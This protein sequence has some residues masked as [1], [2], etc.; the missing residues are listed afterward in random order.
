MQVCFAATSVAAEAAV[1]YAV[2]HFTLSE[3]CRCKSTCSTLSH[4]HHF[5]IGNAQCGFAIA[6]N[7]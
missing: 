4:M 3:P 5:Y 1:V 2:A 7:A 6:V